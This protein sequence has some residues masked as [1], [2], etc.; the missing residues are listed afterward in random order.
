MTRALVGAAIGLCGVAV[1]VHSIGW[2]PLGGVLLLMWGNNIQ[3]D[4]E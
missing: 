2:L 4:R 3:R 1:I